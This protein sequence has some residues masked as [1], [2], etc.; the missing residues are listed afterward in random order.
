MG[1]R[2]T[3]P[4][5]HIYHPADSR[6]EAVPRAKDPK[7]AHCVRADAT[8]RARPPKPRETIREH[9]GGTRTLFVRPFEIAQIDPDRSIGGELAKATVSSRAAGQDAGAR[10]RAARA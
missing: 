3:G 8:A 2:S 1:P 10:D 9:R 6:R 4:V 5:G 7:E